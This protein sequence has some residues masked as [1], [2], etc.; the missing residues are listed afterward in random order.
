MMMQRTTAP[1]PD[2]TPLSAGGGPSAVVVDDA[3]G[4]ATFPVT[5][6]SPNANR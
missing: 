6:V 1:Q 4:D 2:G 3:N 5:P